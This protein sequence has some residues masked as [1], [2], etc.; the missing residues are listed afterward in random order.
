MKFSIP[1]AALLLSAISVLPVQAHET[2]DIV[3]PPRKHNTRASKIFLIGT[4]PARGDVLINGEPIQNRSKSG[5]FAPSVPLEIGQNEFVVEYQGKTITLNINRV[6]NDVVLP[7]GFGF[8]EKSLKPSVPVALM[9]NEPIC[10]KAIATPKQSVSVML[11]DQKI[12]LPESSSAVELPPNS[13]VLTLDN[14]PQAQTASGIYSGCTEFNQPGLKGTPKFVLSNGAG[15]TQE[16]SQDDSVEIFNPANLSKIQVQ[17]EQGVARTGPSTNYSRL[18]PLPKGTEAWV[19]G[20]HGEWVRLDYGAWIKAKE[21]SYIPQSGGRYSIIRSVISRDTPDW[22]EVVFPLENPVPVSV[23]QDSKSLTL[24]LHNTIAQTDTIYVPPDEV[25]DRLDWS[26]PEETKAKYQFNLKTNQAWG[27]KLRYDDTSLILSLRKPPKLG[28]NRKS[29]KGAKIV[30]DAG[31]GS[32]NDLGARGPNAYPEK[33]VTLLVTK[34]LR[35]ELEK[36]GAEVIMTREGDD[37]LWPHDR[38][39]V[40]DAAEP[41][42]AVSI[43]YNALPDAGDAEN[44]KGIGTFWY[45]TQ[46]YDFSVFMHDYLTSKLGRESYGVFWN[47]LAL[48]RPTVTPSILLELGFMI[49]P[50]E[51]EWIADP[52]AQ[53]QLGKAMGDGIT[54]WFH[55]QKS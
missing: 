48:T 37:D 2:F 15:Q 14:K 6:S 43:H 44:T 29:L 50:E 26:H 13:A 32:V 55:R 41:H 30:L 23:E 16:V 10:F 53:V 49:N 36:R 28:S 1:S 17:S 31:H 51:F 38:V 27:Y 18:T 40:I 5:H 25:I 35:D 3:Y 7:Q 52:K 54:E 45:H 12:P 20:R 19:T 11:G 34:L 42:L 4:A 33:D 24:T 8:D 21:V 22:T 39:E 46:A 47:N 9:P